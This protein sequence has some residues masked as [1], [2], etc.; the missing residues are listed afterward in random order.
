MVA[1]NDQVSVTGDHSSA[2][3][4]ALAVSVAAVV[5]PPP[6]ASTVPSGSTVS[7]WNV[8]AK[9]IDATWR[10][11]G[12]GDDTVMSIT[13][14]VALELRMARSG[15]T[16]VPVL[17]NFPGRYMTELPP[18]TAGPPTAYQCSAPTSRTA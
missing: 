12:A 16:D 3:R 4:T 15:S 9:L 18:S 7:E 13:Y 6:L 2:V 11:V 5:G 14:A 17:R 8:R 10:Q 1:S